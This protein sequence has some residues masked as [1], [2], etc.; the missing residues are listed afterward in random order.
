MDTPGD[1]LK[2]ARNQLVM[3]QSQLASKLGM[4]GYQIKDIEIGKTKLHY[5]FAKLL[6]YETGVSEVWLLTGSGPMM[7]SDGP[8]LKVPLEKKEL[9]SSEQSAIYEGEQLDVVS[10]KILLILRDMSEDDRREILKNIEEKK[11][12]RELL[13]ERQYM[14]DTG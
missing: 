1:R 2:I 10:E 12:L 14:K 7:R 3:T 8:A 6:Y 11:L 4:A 5:L 13:K 9:Q